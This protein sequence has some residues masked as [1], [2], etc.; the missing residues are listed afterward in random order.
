MEKNMLKIYLDICSYSRPFDDQ[1]QMKIRLETEAK[2]CIQS[3]VKENKYLLLWSYMLDF[4]NSVNPYEDNKKAISVWKNIARE[5]CPSSDAI[6]ML[7]REIMK[8]GVKE[9]DALH[10]ACAIKSGCEYFIT[11]DRKLLNKL[12]TKIKIINPIDFILETEDIADEN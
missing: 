3:A 10:I 4:E 9:K 1:S 11:T 2:L 5:Y 8:F 12:I 6:L 7:A